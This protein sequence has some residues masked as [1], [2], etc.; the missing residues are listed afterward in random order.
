MKQQTP[1]L[2]SIVRLAKVRAKML[3]LPQRLEPLLAGRLDSR[4]II[5]ALEAEI[6]QALEELTNGVER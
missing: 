6:L 2:D 4:I 5:E 3:E 1:N